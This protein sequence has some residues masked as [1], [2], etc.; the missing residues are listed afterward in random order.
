MVLLPTCRWFIA[1]W[2]SMKIQC[3]V[4]TR[5]FFPQIKEQ[6][7]KIHTPH[8]P[9][10]THPYP[11]HIKLQMQL[12]KCKVIMKLE[13]C[14]VQISDEIMCTYMYMYKMYTE[15][16]LSQY[17]GL[18]NY[19]YHPYKTRVRMTLVWKYPAI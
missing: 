11:V 15:T 8:T 17:V 19:K 14:Q 3:N 2:Q 10:H 9:P 13:Q 6:K 12:A 7:R 18:Y 1:Y 4:Q 5:L 16:N